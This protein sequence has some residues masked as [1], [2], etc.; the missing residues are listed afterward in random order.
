MPSGLYLAPP[1]FVTFTGRIGWTLNE[2][3]ARHPVYQPISPASGRNIT[4][5]C[6]QSDRIPLRGNVKV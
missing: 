3:E 4:L 6:G 2:R 1:Q 5:S